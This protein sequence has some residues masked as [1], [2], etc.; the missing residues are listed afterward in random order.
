M[1]APATAIFS[2]P[3][4]A[5]SFRGCGWPETPD[6]SETSPRRPTV[7]DRGARWGLRWL[8]VSRP[9]CPAQA[10]AA[11]VAGQGLFWVTRVRFLLKPS[12]LH[13]RHGPSWRAHR[14]DPVPPWPPQAQ[15]PRPVASPACGCAHGR[16]RVRRTWRMW[17]AAGVWALRW[18]AHG[19]G[20]PVCA[21]P[22]RAVPSCAAAAENNRPLA[23]LPAHPAAH[24]LVH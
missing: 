6:A 7:R 2:R 9:R 1:H 13:W 4:R 8:W 3:R 10:C 21:V 12:A 24:G 20:A 23:F 14:A 19:L 22:W 15:P 17:R 11:G 18:A 5:G 16:A